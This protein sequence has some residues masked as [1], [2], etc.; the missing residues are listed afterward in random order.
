VQTLRLCCLRFALFPEEPMW[1]RGRFICCCHLRSNVLSLVAALTCF[2]YSLAP[3]CHANATNKFH[4]NFFLRCIPSR[5]VW[6]V[7]SGWS[8]LRCRAFWENSSCCSVL[9]ATCVIFLF[10]LIS[11]CVS[12]CYALPFPILSLSKGRVCEDVLFIHTPTFTFFVFL[13]S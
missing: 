3:S 1:T 10:G 9:R 4:T 13:S 8:S 7:V 11:F 5:L 12:S 6:S 2:L